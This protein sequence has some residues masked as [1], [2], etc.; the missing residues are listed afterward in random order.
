MEAK[1]VVILQ[2]VRFIVLFILGCLW[3]IG[4]AAAF[5]LEGKN[6]FL[7]PGGIFASAVLILYFVVFPFWGAFD[8]RR[9]IRTHANNQIDIPVEF[10]TFLSVI[11]T[12]FIVYAIFP[13]EVMLF[14]GG[15]GGYFIAILLG[16]GNV[17]GGYKL[18]AR[19]I[20]WLLRSL[21]GLRHLLSRRKSKAI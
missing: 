12:I 9:I 2:R 5:A 19:F 21:H 16:V 4:V 15:I 14:S 17:F 1:E 18:T 10:S 8:A 6:F 3:S 7:T 11:I 13:R 20:R